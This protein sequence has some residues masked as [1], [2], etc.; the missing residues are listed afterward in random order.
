MKKADP[1]YTLPDNLTATY[2]Q[3][4][5][6]VQ[7]PEGF[8]WVDSTESV[9]NAGENTF[10]AVYTPAD[11]ENYNTADVDIT[12]AVEKAL[13]TVVLNTE[14]PQGAGGNRSID[15]VASVTGVTG[16]EIPTGTV[17]FYDGDTAISEDIVIADGKRLYMD[18]DSGWRAQLKSSLLRFRQLPNGRGHSKL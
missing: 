16:G 7:L 13:V 11:T 1:I 10:K 9:G 17:V 3:T 2:G 15:L 12:V 5:A 14:N 4:L 8:A 6:N 18:A